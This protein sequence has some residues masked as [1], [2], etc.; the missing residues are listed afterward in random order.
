[1]PVDDGVEHR[2]GIGERPALPLCGLGASGRSAPTGRRRA[3]GTGTCL[4]GCQPTPGFIVRHPL[5]QGARWRPERGDGPPRRPSQRGFRGGDAVH[6]LQVQGHRLLG[7][8]QTHE[9]AGEAVDCLVIAAGEI[10]TLD[11]STLITRAS[12]SASWRVAKG[13]A[14]ACSTGTTRIP[15]RVRGR[16]VMGCSSWHEEERRII[17]RR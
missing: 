9:L 5:G 13:A 16:E 1:M 15:S 8:V 4:R 2:A 6:G 3:S 14:T 17:R 7:A 11:R 12:R 10:T